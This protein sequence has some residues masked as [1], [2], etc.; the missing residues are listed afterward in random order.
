MHGDL[1]HIS[2]YLPLPAA[3]LELGQPVE[4]SIDDAE[5]LPGVING[6]SVSGPIFRDE[7]GDDMV[8]PECDIEDGT[9]K[10]FHMKQSASPDWAAAPIERE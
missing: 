5:R 2:Y 3:E 6:Y 4:V 8:L 1:T 7:N 10:V 9:I